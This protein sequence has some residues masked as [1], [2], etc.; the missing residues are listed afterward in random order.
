MKELKG[1]MR[2]AKPYRW[3]IALATFC[4]VAVTV[5]S[6]AGPWAI[7][8]LIATIEENVAGSGSLTSIFWT[9]GI[10]L[11]AGYRMVAVLL[12]IPLYSQLIQHLPL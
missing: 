11:T 9:F 10:S 3:W 7:R 8:R 6:M 4:M 5:M 2:F 1:L 12:P